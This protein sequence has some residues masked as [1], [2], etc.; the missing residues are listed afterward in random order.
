MEATIRCKITRHTHVF[1]PGNIV[2][3]RRRILEKS[4]N[5]PV[6]GYFVPDIGDGTPGIIPL[7]T[8]EP[9]ADVP[10][11]EETYY[12]K[13]VLTSVSNF[14]QNSADNQVISPN[15]TVEPEKVRVIH[16]PDCQQLVFHMPR[17]AW[18][19]GTFRL[20]NTC[21]QEVIEEKPVRERLNGGT[22]ILT[23][24]LPYP[25]GFYT[26][27]ANWPDGWTHRIQFIKFTEGF[28]KAPFENAPGNFRRAIRNEEVHLLHE[29]EPEIVEGVTANGTPIPDTSFRRDDD[30]EYTSPACSLRM[31]Q[32][33]N[34][35]RLFDYTGREIPTGIDVEKFK[36]ELMSRFFPTLEY[37]QDGRGGSIYYKE[38]DIKIEFGWEF[39]GFNTVVIIFIPEPKYWEAHTGTPLSRRDEILKF[40]CD[41]VIHDQARG[42]KAVMYDDAISIVR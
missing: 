7:D 34:D 27:E 38:G 35:H 29:P 37:T 30:R 13:C 9:L 15:G 25:P 32:D 41:Q 8:A 11:P 33:S 42:C 31:V 10:A 23:N 17:Y 6:S 5:Q 39:G 3:V 2:E 4:E 1:Q 12:G 16:Y 19:A 40:L 14:W 36:K 22:M 28:P 21:S 20:T 18:D 24:T 26:I